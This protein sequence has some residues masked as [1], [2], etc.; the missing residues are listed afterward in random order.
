MYFIPSVKNR[1]AEKGR[2]KIS[3]AQRPQWV[4]IPNIHS[5]ADWNTPLAPLLQYAIVLILVIFIAI[6]AWQLW[7]V[8]ALNL[9][10]PVLIGLKAPP[11]STRQCGRT[12]DVLDQ[13]IE[14][15][16]QLQFPKIPALNFSLT[17]ALVEIL[18][19]LAL[20]ALIVLLVVTLINILRQIDIDKLLDDIVNILAGIGLSSLFRRNK[21]LRTRRKR[22]KHGTGV[23]FISYR[24]K[25]SA[26]E[27]GHISDRLTKRFGKE[28]VFMDN[29]SLHGGDNFVNTLNQALAHC[30]VLLAVIGDHWFETDEITGLNRLEKPDDWVRREIAT[31]LERG[32]PVIQ[33]LV[34]GAAFPQKKDLPEVLAE[35]PHQQGFPIRPDPD[36]RNDMQRLISDIEKILTEQ[37]RQT[38][39]VGRT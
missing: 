35:L 4:Y 31:G 37:T 21:P 39:I 7:C 29:I 24:Q 23:I 2:M 25:D 28:A 14:R 1:S 36:F 27:V 19:G 8:F 15:V 18:V 5:P 10:N 12:M 33:L 26:Y 30:H 13:L 38:N 3:I 32:I 11:V 9:F 17:P 6:T 16:K 20:L 22:K 34:R